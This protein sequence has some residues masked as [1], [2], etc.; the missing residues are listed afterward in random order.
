[1][2]F[3]GPPEAGFSRPYELVN[4]QVRNYAFEASTGRRASKADKL[5]DIA[6]RPC[7][8]GFMTMNRNALRNGRVSGFTLIELLVVITIIAVLV[9]FLFPMVLKGR[10]RARHHTVSKEISF[11]DA[12]LREYLKE[13]TN[14]GRIREGVDELVTDGIAVDA[15]IVQTL[16]GGNPDANPKRIRFYDLTDDKLDDSLQFV[17]PWGNPYKFMFD[18]NGDGKITVN[19]SEG[20]DEVNQPVAIWSR[21]TNADEDDSGRKDDIRNW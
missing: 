5:L 14:P 18:F 1:M 8:T 11:L 4:S 12:A 3:N 7:H 19:V 16:R 21:G 15:D 10:E 9:G 6:M 20:Q 13:Y 17:D 2:L